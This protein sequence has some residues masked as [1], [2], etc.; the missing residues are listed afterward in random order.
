M[1][2]RS[3]YTLQPINSTLPIN[4]TAKEVTLS[5]PILSCVLTNNRDGVKAGRQE[6]CSSIQWKE[7]RQSGMLWGV[8][9][10]PLRTSYLFSTLSLAPS[11]PR[12]NPPFLPLISPD[13]LTCSCLYSLFIP[14]LPFR[15]PCLG[16]QACFL[17]GLCS[18]QSSVENFLP[19]TLYSLP[20]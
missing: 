8:L 15:P 3:C 6:R 19:Q 14:N 10:D 17:G 9:S 4:S 5:I 7:E 2:H 11:C 18:D 13:G 20:P 12:I 1:L 16:S